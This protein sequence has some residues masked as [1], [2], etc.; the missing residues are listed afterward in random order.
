VLVRASA[1]NQQRAHF[2]LGTQALTQAEDAGKRRKDV[3]SAPA[4][5]PCSVPVTAPYSRGYGARTGRGSGRAK[6]NGPEPSLP[7]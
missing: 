6:F 5:F 7:L 3:S 1:E 2:D 4:S